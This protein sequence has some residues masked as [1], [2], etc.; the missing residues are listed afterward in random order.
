MR[1]GAV[2]VYIKWEDGGEVETKAPRR[3]RI[4]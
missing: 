3:I 4:L 1:K 2:D